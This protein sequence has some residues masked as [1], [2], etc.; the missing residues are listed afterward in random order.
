MS[1]FFSIII[2]IHLTIIYILI[3]IFQII[4]TKY[5]PMCVNQNVKAKFHYLFLSWSPEQDEYI[6]P[7]KD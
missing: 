7:K 6:C 5:I 2:M 3:V 1:L 4:Y